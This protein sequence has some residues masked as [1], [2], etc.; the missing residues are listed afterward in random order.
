MVLKWPGLAGGRV[1]CG[2]HYQIDVA[3]TI[4]E[5]LCARVV[6]NWDGAGFADTLRHGGETGRE[7]LVVSQGAWTAQRAVRF[8]DYIC[9]RTYHD[10][11]QGFPNIMLFDLKRDPHETRDLAQEQP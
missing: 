5:L 9:I 4:L 2:L 8:G 6:S 11:Y 1:D 7:Y 3:A 10:G